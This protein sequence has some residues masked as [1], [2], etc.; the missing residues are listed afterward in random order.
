MT[1]YADGTPVPAV[2]VDPECAHI[3]LSPEEIRRAVWARRTP[4][5]IPRPGELVLVR[6]EEF[7]PRLTAQVA[8]VQDPSTVA[9]QRDPYIW[10]R[11][12]ETGQPVAMHPDPW[13][14]L[15]LTTPD[16][17]HKV[18]GPVLVGTVK[19]REGRARGSPGWL[20][21]DWRPP[22]YDPDLLMRLHHP[23]A[24]YLVPGGE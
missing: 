22:R 6:F 11:D 18:T 10:R 12:N 4:T 17:A 7:G 16:E 24:R 8:G 1:F 9:S 5:R 15:L 3:P 21:L 14:E 13:P 19:C 20:P 2:V 23:Q